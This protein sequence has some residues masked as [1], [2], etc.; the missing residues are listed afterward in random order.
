MLISRNKPFII[1]ISRYM[2]ICSLGST[3]LYLFFQT[4]LE[5]V[6]TDLVAELRS[7]VARW[8]D[9]LHK[10]QMAKHQAESGSHG[11]AMLSPI[12][13]AMLGD[14]PIRMITLGQEL[15]VDMDEKSLGELQFKDNQVVQIESIHFCLFL[16]IIRLLNILDSELYIVCV[17]SEGNDNMYVYLL[18]PPLINNNALLC[19]VSK[20]YIEK[21]QPVQN[22]AA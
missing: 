2:Y 15:T 12:L 6:S 5:M 17:Q 16:F 19:G 10:Q 22:T 9:G 7:E 14:G 8:W 20:T 13:G 11:N 18:L 4:Q 3:S 21:F 1:L